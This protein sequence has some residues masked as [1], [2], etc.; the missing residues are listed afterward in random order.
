MGETGCGKTYLLHYM[1]DVLAMKM[2]SVDVCNNYSTIK[3]KHDIQNARYECEKTPNRQIVLFFDEINTSGDIG[4]FKEIVCDRTFRGEP[5]PYNLVVIGALNPYREKTRTSAFQYDMKEVD[6]DPLL[7]KMNSLVYR[8]YQ[9]PQSMHLYVWN[10]GH[11]SEENEG[12][13]IS[14]MVNNACMA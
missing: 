6:E 5:L 1:A 9:L 3:L 4:S 8:V 13:Y 11:L 14:I 2:I 10:F 12:Q 7:R